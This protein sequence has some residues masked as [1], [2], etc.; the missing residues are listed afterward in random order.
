[1]KPKPKFS[2]ESLTRLQLKMGTSDNKM[3]VLSNYLRINCGRDS[4]EKLQQHMI[5]R[6]KRLEDFFDVKNLKQTQYI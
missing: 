3:K 2:N 5:E 1:M 4:V 6:N